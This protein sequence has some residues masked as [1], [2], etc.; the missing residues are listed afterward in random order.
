MTKTKQI[1]RPP[2][3]GSLK[4][5]KTVSIDQKQLKRIE[6]RFGSLTKY[7]AAKLLDDNI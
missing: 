6:K 2:K 7:I 1:G 5:S 3:I 4:I